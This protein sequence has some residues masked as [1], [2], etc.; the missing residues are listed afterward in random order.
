MF[1]SMKYVFLENIHNFYRTFS[2]AKYEILADMRFKIR[3]I[4]EFCASHDTDFNLLVCFWLDH[5][6]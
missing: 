4:L 5:A 3:F 2:I 6:K 1:K